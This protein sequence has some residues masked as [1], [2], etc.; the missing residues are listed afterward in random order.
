MN[1][2]RSSEVIDDEALA[3]SACSA[4]VE[5]VF[6][7]IADSGDSGDSIGDSYDAKPSLWNPTVAANLSLF[8]SPIF[9]A[10]IH[11]NNWKVLGFPDRAAANRNWIW[12]Y[13]IFTLLFMVVI[14][15]VPEGPISGPVMMFL[16][17]T[18][19]IGWYWIE[20]KKQIRYVRGQFGKGYQRRRWRKPIF[21]AW[22][23]AAI[24]N[25]TL[26]LIFLATFTVEPPSGEDIADHI[27]PS[28][29]PQVRTMFGVPRGRIKNLTLER[30]E[31]D[32]FEG[33]FEFHHGDDVRKFRLIVFEFED[34]YTWEIQRNP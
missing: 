28:L 23:L 18:P 16:P 10:I 5:L 13:L 32:R 33:T 1:E 34:G 22:V 8:F 2:A 3:E 14:C 12:I 21:I 7:E 29:T 27:R 19:L 4:D 26:A 20:G 9:G 24:F 6:H 30:T 31:D 17:I 11:A 25:V 15:L